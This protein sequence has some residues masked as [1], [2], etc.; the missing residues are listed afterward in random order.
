MNRQ[1]Q[2]CIKKEDYKKL[3]TDH[4]LISKK[5]L[6][7]ILSSDMYHIYLEK[8]LKYYFYH[9]KIIQNVANLYL[10]MMNFYQDNFGII[11]KKL[12][13]F[14]KKLFLTLVIYEK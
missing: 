3:E 9:V 6:H 10:K 13:N 4:K 8:Y 7:N 2:Y 11:Q 14:S 5:N 1:S 12:A